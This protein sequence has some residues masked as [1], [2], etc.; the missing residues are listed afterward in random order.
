MSLKF[1]G[2]AAALAVAFTSLPVSGSTSD[3]QDSGRGKAD[4]EDRAF[5]EAAGLTIAEARQYRDMTEHV[6]TLERRAMESF[7]ASYA[8]LWRDP[9]QGGRVFVA[10]TTDTPARLRAVQG[11]FP[12]PDLLTG[13]TAQFS[14]AQLSQVHRQIGQ[15]TERRTLD[16]VE[17][18]LVAVDLPS[19]RVLVWVAD[20][21]SAH[22]FYQQRYGDAVRLEA[23]E[24]RT[25][26]CTRTNC[27]GE[28]MRG[29]LEFVFVETNAAYS[30]TTAFSA[31]R[32]SSNLVG[33]LSAGHC[34]VVDSPVVHAGFPMG[35]VAYSQFSGNNDSLFVDQV[36]GY[37]FGV[38]GWVWEDPGF[39]RKPILSVAAAA[40]G[41]VGDPVCHS[42][43]TRGHRC[44]V[45]KNRGVSVSVGGVTLTDM[46]I[47]DICSLP[48]DS[49][50]PVYF[51]SRAH[52]IISASNYQGGS[53]PR[54]HDTNP[55]SVYS[56]I[57]NVEAA[58]G[59]RVIFN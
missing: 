59:V 2:L 56:K 25:T 9:S 19:N 8:G 48:G 30:C 55:I 21:I 14:L 15:D 5:A 49:G 24:L 34:G 22:D 37:L 54:C 40:G 43:K 38:R 33:L 45:I 3:Y 51:N 6:H 18:R 7:P 11:D 46:M 42:G 20:P 28:E 36:D 50:G 1:I 58:H 32:G 10:F 57:T 16:G 27:L 4:P 35:V 53:V 12:Q 52:G 39:E 17:P 31:T 41:A 47:D 13:V 44:G 23:G 26:A 29:G